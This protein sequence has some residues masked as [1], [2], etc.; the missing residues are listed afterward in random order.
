MR[1]PGASRLMP[2]AMPEG[3]RHETRSFS[4]AAGSRD[5]VLYVPAA[6]PEGPQGLVR[7]LH[8]CTQ[9]AENF[10][11]GTDMNR[12]A[13]RYGFIV[14]Y[15]EQTRTHNAQACWNWSG[16]AIRLRTGANP[17]FSPEWRAN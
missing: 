10:A 13:E 15:P 5:Y 11:R 1:A 3:A 4:C 17:P 14:G 2:P 12:V 16:P 6:L 8:G 7:M 9:N